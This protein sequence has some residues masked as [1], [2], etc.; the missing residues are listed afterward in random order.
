LPPTDYRELS[1]RNAVEASS[2]AR[3]IQDRMADIAPLLRPAMRVLEIGCAE[4]SLGAVIRRSTPVHYTGVELSGDAAV[5]AG[6]LDCVIRAPAATIVD[7][8]FD[9]L[10]SF[11]VLE[12]VA[13]ITEEMRHWRR[14]LDDAGTLIV[15]VPNR[16][17]HR[18]LEL[19]P[20]PEH[21]HQF[22]T[23][24]LAALLIREDFEIDRIE[25]DHWESAVYSDSLRVVARPAVTG[26]RRRALLLQ[27][28]RS[29]LPDQFAAWGIGGDFRAYVE[30]LLDSLPVAA[31]ID[32]AEQ[33]LGE[34]HGHLTV[35]AYDEQQHGSL[36]IL[37]CSVRYREEILRDLDR[38]GIPSSRIV[39]LDDVFGP[40]Q[41]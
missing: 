38:L 21:L 6:V 5:A 28:F 26:A 11:H 41:P 29:H 2:H 8:K 4:G 34:R 12:H 37:V 39:S 33:R 40:A 10:L 17:G 18:L 30:P 20:N 16:A 23:A 15:E 25:S 27:R 35:E 13:D 1:G 7:E 24:S 19:D 9:L 14:L 32:A 22:T 36:P 31:L 3:K